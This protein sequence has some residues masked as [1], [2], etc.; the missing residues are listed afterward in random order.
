MQNVIGEIVRERLGDVSIVKLLEGAVIFRTECTYDKLN[1]FCFNNIFAVMDLLPVN[2]GNNDPL[3]YHIRK[4]CASGK[5]NGVKGIFSENAAEVISE[6]NNKIKTF[7]VVCSVENKPAS[8]H[9][10][11]RAG[12]ENFIT[13]N[14]SL[15]LNRTK[16]DTEFWFLYRREGISI[17][18]KR[19]TRSVE[20]KLHDGELSP[21]L[22]WL[23]C[24]IASLR[25]EETVMD[26]FCGY[27]AIP[28]AAL[29]H[30]PIKKFIAAD[31]NRQ[32]IEITRAKRALKNPRCEIHLTD[33]FSQAKPFSQ[34]IYGGVDAIVTDPPWGIY[35]E[36][37]VPIE[38]FYIKT[39]ALFYA[40]LSKD[41]RVVVLTGAAHALGTALEATGLFNA[42]R[43]IPVLVSGRKASVFFMEKK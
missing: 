3:E 17:F 39:L 8:V 2:S 27:G 16:P 35:Q 40:I 20:K 38:E 1:F 33:I 31:I 41:G 26:P 22:A 30:F 37:G 15:K 18:M 10:L 14:S 43:I 21:Q 25:P 9:E 28:E 42:N 23:L 19:L 7:R 11:T 4:I 34:D 36:T 13:G 6:N 5:R 24:R 32:C 29:K 12:I